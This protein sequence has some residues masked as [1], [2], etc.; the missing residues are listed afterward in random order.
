MVSLQNIQDWTAP[1]DQRPVFA[2]GQRVAQVSYQGEPVRKRYGLV[3]MVQ[4]HYDKRIPHMYLVKPEGELAWVWLA[5]SD[6]EAE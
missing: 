3:Q 4:P 1:K 6:L 5:E 2:A